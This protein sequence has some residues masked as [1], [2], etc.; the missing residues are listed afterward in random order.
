MIRGMARC[1]GDKRATT[2]RANFVVRDQLAFDDRFIASRLNHTRDELHWTIARRR[3]QELDR[4]LSRDRAWRLVGAALLHQVP[5][6]SPVAMTVQERADDT[7]VQHA[8]IG[9][10]FRA[11][12][13]LGDDHIAVGEAADVQ[14]FWVCRA[15]AE[16]GEIWRERFLNALHSAW[17]LDLCSLL[18]LGQQKVQRTK[19][20]EQRSKFS[21]AAGA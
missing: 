16:A 17:Y 18:V 11:R 19:Y 3:A 12:L 10:V 4:V 6:C 5:R 9:F 2:S 14:T 13:P 20:K 7:A 21:V 1:D 8:V 15:A